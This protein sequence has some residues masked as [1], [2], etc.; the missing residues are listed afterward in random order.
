M[1]RRNL[2]DDDAGQLERAGSNRRHLPE[3]RIMNDDERS[4]DRHAAMSLDRGAER[5]NA[6]AGDVS[7]QQERLLQIGHLLAND[8]DVQRIAVLDQ[9]M[10]VAVKH[11]TARCAEVQRALVIVLRHLGEA[12]MLPDLEVPEADG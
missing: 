7:Q 12:S 1:T 11:H 9:H 4:V 6:G 5:V 3:R 2:L 10:A 8:G